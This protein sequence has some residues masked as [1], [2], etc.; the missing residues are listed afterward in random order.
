[1][2][3]IIQVM[4]SIPSWENLLDQLQIE[5]GSALFYRCGPEWQPV[6]RVMP[7]EQL[8]LIHAGQLE[9]TIGGRVCRA[10]PRQVVFC[11]PGIEWNLKRISREFVQLTVIHFQALFPGGRRFLEAF[12]LPAILEPNT[13]SWSALVRIARKLCVLNKQKPSGHALKELSLMFEFFHEVFPMRRKTA[14]VDPNGG[15]ILKLIAF[16]RQ[17]YRER[18]TLETLGRQVFLS[19][20]HL[21][22]LFRDYTGH[23][24]IDYLIQVRIEEARRLLHSPEC[25][26]AEIAERVGYEDP[27]YF[28]RLFRKHAGMSPAGFRRHCRSLT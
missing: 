7:D 22:A 1:M 20:N 2:D 9:Y 25:T 26:I 27:A 23:S 10:R 5:L 16:M 28:S 3:D 19:P 18:I 8:H 24:P 14:A 13:R 21:A 4:I 11:P 15:R 6:P 17:H 12:G